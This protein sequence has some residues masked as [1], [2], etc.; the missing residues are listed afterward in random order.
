MEVFVARQPIFDKKQRVF[1]YEL[2]YRNGQDDF[3]NHE[4]G[5][6]A[7]SG[8]INSL[9]LI[10]I[11]KLTGGKRAF[12][13]FTENLLKQQIPTVFTKDTIVIE[14][15]EDIEPTQ[16]IIDACRN[17]KEAGY[18]LA[19]D[20]FVFHSKYNPLI[21]FVD[22]IKVDFLNTS[23]QERKDIL[24][25]VNN[26]KVK[27]LAEKV[28]TRE[29]FQQ[30]LEMGYSYFQGYFFGKPSILSSIDIPSSAL[31]SL[32]IFREM[33]QTD[34]N[35]DKIAK[36]IERDVSLSYKLLRLINSSAFSF[37]V[38]ISSIK[39]ALKQL[40]IE[41]FKKW[42]TLI[43][44][45]DMENQ[46]ANEI[47]KLSTI[48]AKFGELLASRVELEE[49]SSEIF[50]MGMFSMIDALMNQS[51]EVILK[52]LPLSKDL[53]LAL[54]GKKSEFADLY[55]FILAYEKGEWHKVSRFA[56]QFDLK[57]IEVSS[58]FID[59]L[60]WTNEIFVS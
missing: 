58:L 21:D 59:A 26:N 4:D 57:E 25:R 11:E 46:H 33:N 30:A 16:E 42:V 35:C 8:V 12:I 32:E 36:I 41:E 29:E 2:L 27:F 24:K 50:L 19:L 45:K 54:L 39:Q 48:R 28:E 1:A 3:Y 56:Q 9:F 13:N 37:N 60:E 34:P 31:N 52:E 38:N 6:R 17:L 44:L 20:D 55:T 5:D 40:G 23:M 18:V 53:K 10:G 49:R 51:L 14:I 43:A 47:I 7:T 22:I 15:L